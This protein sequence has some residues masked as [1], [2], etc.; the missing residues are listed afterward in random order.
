MGWVLVWYVC[1]YWFACCGFARLVC[2]CVGSVFCWCVPVGFYLIALFGFL[3]AVFIVFV[4]DCVCAALLGV[5]VLLYC[6][7][8]CGLL[9]YLLCSGF[10]LVV[11]VSCWR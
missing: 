4:S 11:F 10:G 3:I 6:C 2:V 1:F 5:L 7:F 8:V 9:G